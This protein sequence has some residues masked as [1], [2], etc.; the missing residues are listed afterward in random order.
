MIPMHPEL[1][2]RLATERRAD[3]AADAARR[4]LV[5]QAREARRAADSI[6]DRSITDR[7]STVRPNRAL[8]LATWLRVRV[9]A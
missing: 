8:R 5:R 7:T 6:T 2:S 4:G 3:L 9:P 1:I